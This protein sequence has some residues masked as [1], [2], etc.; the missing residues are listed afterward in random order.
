MYDFGSYQISE[1]CT[2]REYKLTINNQ[3]LFETICHIIKLSKILIFII[4]TFC[5]YCVK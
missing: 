1:A 5:F 3:K 2:K 4:C